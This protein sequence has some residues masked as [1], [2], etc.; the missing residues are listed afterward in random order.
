MFGELIKQLRLD[1]RISL[2]DFCARAERDP[3]NW[4]KVERGVLPPPTDQEDLDKICSTLDLERG[5]DL[6]MK[7]HDAAAIDRGI[8]PSDVM[9]DRELLENLPTFFRTL[10]GQKPSREERERL[11]KLIRRS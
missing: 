11:I 10:R 4:S 5:S 1:R 3:S 6:W 7:V 8:I 2:R 9:N